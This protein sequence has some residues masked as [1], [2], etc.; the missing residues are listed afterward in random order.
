MW[1]TAAMRTTVS[2]VQHRIQVSDDARFL[3]SGQIRERYNCSDMSIYRHMAAHGFPKPVKFGGPT[4]ARRW[5]LSEIEEWERER[6][7][8]AG[9]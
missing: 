1:E 9:N 7:K 8:L 6:A 5:R 2:S 4:S 3:T